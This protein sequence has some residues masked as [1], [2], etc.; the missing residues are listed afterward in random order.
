M[1]NS[2]SL[3]LAASA[4]TSNESR[5][6]NLVVLVDSVD[7]AVVAVVDCVIWIGL[8]SEF[9]CSLV[10]SNE[11]RR[12]RNAAVDINDDDDDDT[13]I[14]FVGVEFGESSI[15]DRI[16]FDDVNVVVV[17]VDVVLVVDDDD[18]LM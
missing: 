3:A 17:V 7:I 14:G 5:R 10:K 15:V 18:A 4:L 9:D 11:L 1:P 13:W 16:D 12:V 8:L 6:I 2:E